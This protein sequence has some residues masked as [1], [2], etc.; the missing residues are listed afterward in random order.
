MLF[1]GINRRGVFLNLRFLKAVN[2][3]EVEI[4]YFVPSIIGGCLAL[5]RQSGLVLVE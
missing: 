2:A 1:I 4:T 5:D 3:I